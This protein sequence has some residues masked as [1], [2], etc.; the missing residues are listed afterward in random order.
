MPLEARHV[1]RWIDSQLVSC[2]M[3]LLLVMLGHGRSEFL[4]SDTIAWYNTTCLRNIHHF[5]VWLQ[6]QLGFRIEI[7]VSKG[8]STIY[9]KK[10]RISQRQNRLEI[11]SILECGANPIFNC[12]NLMSHNRTKW[13]CLSYR[14]LHLWLWTCYEGHAAGRSHC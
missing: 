7:L 13:C 8:N 3:Q 2:A 6:I 11:F 5:L 12:K 10:T 14:K 9:T 4:L 1:H